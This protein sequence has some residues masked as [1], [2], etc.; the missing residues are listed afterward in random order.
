[1]LKQLQQELEALRRTRASVRAL[2]RMAACARQNIQIAIKNTDTL[3][4]LNQGWQI[5]F[6]GKK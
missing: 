5:F 3:S 6:T 4:D 2:E 1:E